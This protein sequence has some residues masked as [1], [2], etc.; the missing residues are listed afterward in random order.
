MAVERR[1]VILYP[2]LPRPLL[3]ITVGIAAVV[4]D[5]EAVQKELLDQF[6]VLM[7]APGAEAISQHAAQRRSPA[8]R[9]HC[10]ARRV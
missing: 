8:I 6:E 5:E 3:M 10:D 7:G 2:S 1:L 9:D 4:A